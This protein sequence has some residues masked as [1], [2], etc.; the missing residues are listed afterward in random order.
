M[1]TTVMR[2]RN[3]A[4]KRR[5]QRALQRAAN[6]IAKREEFI[7]KYLGALRERQRI[8]KQSENHGGLV[9]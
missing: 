4:G 3:G 8:E 7:E 6:T 5:N 2:F 9:F 1:A